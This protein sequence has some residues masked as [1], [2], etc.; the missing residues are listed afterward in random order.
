MTPLQIHNRLR[1]LGGLWV[2]VKGAKSDAVRI[3]HVLAYCGPEEMQRRILA[4][5]PTSD[6]Q[7]YIEFRTRIA[8]AVTEDDLIRLLREQIIVDSEAIQGWAGRDWSNALRSISPPT[9]K[10]KVAIRNAA[11]TPDLTND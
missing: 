10:G 7:R 4:A 8:M 3:G 1:Y 9:T 11:T 5:T 6:E 2:S